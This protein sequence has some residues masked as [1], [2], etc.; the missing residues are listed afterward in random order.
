MLAIVLV[1]CA[2]FF[3]LWSSGVSAQENVVIVLD[4]SGSMNNRMKTGSSRI[5]A[6]KKALASVLKQFHRETKLGLLLLNGSRTKDHWALPLQPLSV[7]VASQLIS[8]LRADGG[9]PLG[10]RIRDGAEA[11]LKAR[12]KQ[13]Y[14]TYR[15]LIVS[16]GEAE[17]HRLLESYLPDI[18]S[19]GIIV[20]AI[21]VDMKQDHSL[22]T[23]VHSYRRADDDAALEKAI[24]EV[25]A[26]RF[27][28]TAAGSKDDYQL[29]AA[30]DDATA[31]EVLLAISKPNNTAIV[32]VSKPT[33]WGET[34]PISV[35][36]PTWVGI[37]VGMMSCLIPLVLFVFIVVI[38]LSKASGKKNRKTW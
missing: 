5:D 23:R 2:S 28:S 4:D 6:A 18:L 38:M 33:A 30:L 1:T 21:G 8:S 35:A 25:F 31:R 11:L 19:R 37:L 16:D 22:A 15:L 12:E 27:D 29:L 20:D 26:E 32:G 7:G 24:Q 9:T 17:D 13:Y 34:S 3:G 14:G 10:E 36:A